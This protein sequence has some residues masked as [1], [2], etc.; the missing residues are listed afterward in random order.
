[1]NE[2][3]YNFV[4]GL[5]DDALI[6]GQRL[7]ELCSNGPYMEEDLALTNT[8]LDYIGRASLFYQYASEISDKDCTENDLAYLRNE[9]EYT[10]LL[11]NE[12]PNG[13]FAFTMCKQYFLDVF[14]RLYLE[15]LMQSSDE[16]LAA[17]AAK[18]IKETNYH[19]K[20]SEQWMRQLALGTDESLHR[21][22]VA[23]EEIQDYTNELF[24]M[25]DDEQALVED[26]IS[27]DRTSL[28][29]DWK[30][31]VNSHFVSLGLSELDDTRTIEGGRN[32]IHTEHL[33]HILSEMQFIQRAYP[34]QEW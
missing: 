20:R 34:G 31:H 14:Y 19:L 12:L 26:G 16:H 4:I 21:L 17:I 6:L 9:R 27:V 10:N 15:K 18:S 3:L 30:Q 22:Q 25:S 29:A 8:A 24:K 28:L 5:A 33:G 11:I 2:N 32:G 13:D 1:M 23:I 7:S